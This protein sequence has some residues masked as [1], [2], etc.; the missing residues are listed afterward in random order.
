MTHI[1]IFGISVY[2][3]LLFSNTKAQTLANTLQTFKL[4]KQVEIKSKDSLFSNLKPLRVSKSLNYI[5][6]VK[7]MA[8]FDMKLSDSIVKNMYYEYIGTLLSFIG[9]DKNALDCFDSAENYKEYINSN[10]TEFNSYSLIEYKEQLKAKASKSKIVLINEMHHR[11]VCRIFTFEMLADFR[12]QGYN[13]LAL[14]TLSSRIDA[15]TEKTI[16]KNLGFYTQEPNFANLVRYAKFL[17][18]K[19]VAY[20]TTVSDSNKRD[21]LAAINIMKV[22]DKDPNAKMII[23][24]GYGHANTVDLGFHSI[25]V[26]LKDKYKFVK[27]INQT[28]FNTY[29]N[30]QFCNNFYA[31]LDPKK[32]I[33]Y[34]KL[35]L[36]KNINFNPGYDFTLFENFNADDYKKSLIKNKLFFERTLL[37][38][39]NIKNKS[40]LLQYYPANEIRNITD[41]DL[42][43]PASNQI[44]KSNTVTT[45]LPVFIKKYLIIIRDLDNKI[46]YKTSFTIKQYLTIIASRLPPK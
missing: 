35:L 5:N 23:H 42:V 6:D 44:I 2:L 28:Y 15:S 30:L 9:E 36:N 1:K 10:V 7:A 18:F 25:G 11:P 26:W 17:K 24:C 32:T 37:I 34:P 8:S 31:Y 14:E 20:D 46:I 29:G 40:F 3:V 39:K 41:Y 16:H 33:K 45:Y 22:L 4:K 43:V 12:K 21:S 38:P 19:L 27:S 13:Y